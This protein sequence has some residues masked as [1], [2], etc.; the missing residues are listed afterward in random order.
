MIK[1]NDYYP[2]E[3]KRCLQDKDFRHLVEVDFES[4]SRVLYSEQSGKALW[5]VSLYLNL[6]LIIK[7]INF[8]HFSKNGSLGISSQS[9]K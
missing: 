4:P 7:S 3:V 2:G 5:F 1:S 8:T 6:Y 9:Q